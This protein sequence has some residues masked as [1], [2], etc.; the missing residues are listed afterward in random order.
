MEERS[1]RKL[2]RFHP[3]STR[4]RRAKFHSIASRLKASVLFQEIFGSMQGGSGDWPALQLPAGAAERE[5][6]L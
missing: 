4:V 6:R 1:G 3:D 5:A 2:G